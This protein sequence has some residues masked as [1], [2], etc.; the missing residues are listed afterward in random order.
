MLSHDPFAL[1]GIDASDI[2]ERPPWHR[3]ALCREH[4]ELSW[5]PP[6]GDRADL[7]R[8][9]C[10]RCAVRRECADA[11]QDQYGIWGGLSR[12]ERRAA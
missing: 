5:F 10:R 2:V 12:A 11:G 6:S 8:A 7:Q 4:P 9:I 3:D 1:I